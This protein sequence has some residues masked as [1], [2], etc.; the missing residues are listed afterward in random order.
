MLKDGGGIHGNG[1]EVSW[2]KTCRSVQENDRVVPARRSGIN[3]V[4]PAGSPS[5]NVFHMQAR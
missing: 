4:A 5:F 1:E 3:G 2:R